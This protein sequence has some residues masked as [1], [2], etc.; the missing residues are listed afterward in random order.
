MDSLWHGWDNL[1]AK[2][3]KVG[4]KRKGC[5]QFMRFHNRKTGAVGIGKRLVLIFLKDQPGP[6]LYVLINR[7]DLQLITFFY[8]IPKGDR[9][10]RTQLPF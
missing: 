8:L 6:F 4:I 5:F 1:E 9:G 3:F 10:M 2:D 7:Y